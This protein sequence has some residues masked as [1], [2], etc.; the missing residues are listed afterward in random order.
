MKFIKKKWVRIGI[1]GGIIAVML[2]AIVT[3]GY[4]LGTFA[5]HKSLNE[6]YEPKDNMGT[7]EGDKIHFLDIA[8]GDAI[9]IES[10]GH[11]ALVDAGED[12]DN[13]TGKK[14][15][16]L[17]GSEDAVTAYIKAVAGDAD[18]KV[19]LDFVLG[20][21]A[22]SDHIGGLDTVVL[23]PDITIDRAYLKIYDASHMPDFELEWDN[24]EVYNQAISALATRG[25]PVISAIP[26]ESFSLGN[27]AV[28]IYNGGYDT[29]GKTR[30]ENDNS[31][32]VLLDNGKKRAFL[33]GDI[34]NKSGDE[35]K[36]GRL[37]GKVDLLKVGHHGYGGSNTRGYL[38]RLKPEVA[39]ATNEL[40]NVPR[41]TINR[42]TNAVHSAFY[43]TGSYG[44]IIAVLG[45]KIVLYEGV[46]IKETMNKYFELDLMNFSSDC[47]DFPKPRIGIRG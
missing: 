1:L 22:H 5:V 43:C 20:T 36:L 26:E 40:K 6:V 25:I 3:G 47:D 46:F 7:I 39:I 34:N 28:T 12:N 27:F 24:Q 23:D 17:A 4:Y 10:A 21:H 2:A 38:R 37:I 19:H 18:G 9:L 13:P 30:D 14:D 33:S 11:F 15:L 31:M 42:F 16:E 35:K 45:E 29:D 44:G 8:S 32:G 41:T